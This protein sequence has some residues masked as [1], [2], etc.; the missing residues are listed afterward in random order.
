MSQVAFPGEA[1]PRHWVL[2]DF[3]WAMERE[4]KAKS[5]VMVAATL[6]TVADFIAAL[7]SQ[8]GKPYVFG[9][10]NPAVGFDCSGLV[11]WAAAQA[12]VDVPRT[13]QGEW[14]GLLHVENPEPGDLIL[15]NVPSDGPPQPQ[16]VMVYLGPNQAIQAPHTG[17]DVE[18]S[19]I[20]NDAGEQIMGYCRIPFA[21]TPPPAPPAPP[22]PPSL[23]DP[24]PVSPPFQWEGSNHIL[25]ISFGVIWNKYGVGGP[26]AASENIVQKAGEN[27]PA[28]AGTPPQFPDQTPQFDIDGVLLQVSA[29]DSNGR[30]WYFVQQDNLPGWNAQQVP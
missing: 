9:A 28:I 25:Q 14:S 4:L 2:D 19:G 23:E 10:D 17:A 1:P 6:G 12:G 29:Q 24:M 15:Y 16:H 13:T 20:P 26:A 8:L 22:P 5:L 21:N 30:V 3:I 18:Y 7:E 27:N 11:Y